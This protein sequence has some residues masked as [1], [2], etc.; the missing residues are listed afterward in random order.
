MGFAEFHQARAFGVSGDIAL[1]RHGTQGVGLAF[2]RTH[3]FSLF[4]F[5]AL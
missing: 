4:S 1:E 5:R 2:G 3:G